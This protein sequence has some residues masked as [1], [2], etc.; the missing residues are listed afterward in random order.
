M[1]T[2]LVKSGQQWDFPNCWP[3]LEHI[4]VQGL[5][6]TGIESAKQLAFRLAEKRVRGAFVNHKVT[7]HMFEKVIKLMLLDI[8]R[9]TT[10]SLSP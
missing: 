2:S 1:P 9:L 6:R 5:E 3:P 10:S 4:V 8:T 7:G